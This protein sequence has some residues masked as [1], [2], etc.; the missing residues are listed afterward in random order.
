MW[1]RSGRARA[2]VY[3]EESIPPWYRGPRQLDAD[4]VAVHVP[5][6]YAPKPSAVRVIHHRNLT[7]GYEGTI[8]RDPDALYHEGR[9]CPTDAQLLKLKPSQD[10]EACVIGTTEQQGHPG[11]MGA[12]VL[13]TAEGQT[14]RV[15]TG[16]TAQ[17]RSEMGMSAPLGQVARVTFLERTAKGLP[18]HPV[19]AGFRSPADLS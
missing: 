4:S 2:L 5:A 12:L 17:E 16:F 15:G 3:G 13:E 6:V 19:F 1:A 7:A 8:L 14:F 9:T 10:M 18:R 11:T